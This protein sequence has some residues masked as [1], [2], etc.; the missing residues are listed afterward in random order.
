ML[1]GFQTDL[2]KS[3]RTL[4]DNRAFLFLGASC[5]QLSRTPHLFKLCRHELSNSNQSLVL[6]RLCHDEAAALCLYFGIA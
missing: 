3:L 4:C 1:S 6:L 2:P 5:W